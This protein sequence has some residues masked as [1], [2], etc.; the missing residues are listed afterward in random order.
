METKISGMNQIEKFWPIGVYED[1][2]HCGDEKNV[3]YENVNKSGM[4]R[5]EP[6]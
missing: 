1:L 6:P 5:S 4:N 3:T 2:L